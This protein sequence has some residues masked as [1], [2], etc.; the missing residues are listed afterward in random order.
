MSNDTDDTLTS[1]YG[2]L[3]PR[4]EM[5]DARLAIFERDLG[6]RPID[7]ALYDL[8]AESSVGQNSVVLDVGCGQGRQ[9][10]EIANRLACRVIAVDPVEH[11]LRLAAERTKSEGVAD[12]V[13]LRRGTLEALPAGDGEIDLIWCMDTFNHARDPARALREFARVLKPGGTIFNCSALETPSLEPREKE[14]LCRTL[15]LNPQ[16]LSA[17]TF[18]PLLEASGLRVRLNGS[19]CEAGSKF[20]EAIDDK[21]YRHMK[22][23][24]HMARDEQRLIAVLGEKD[25]L[26]LKA[27]ALWNAYLFMGKITY[28]V[29]VLEIGRRNVG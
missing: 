18:E 20:F 24:A 29:W 12:R 5:A 6:G 27:H 28:H 22:R 11:C 13:E 21:D 25:Y 16:T 17:G 15:A 3:W 1:F 26:I 23:L 4:P 7:E 10:C 9:A 8:A 14:W 19:T 2:L